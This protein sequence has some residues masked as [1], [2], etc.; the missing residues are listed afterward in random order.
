VAGGSPVTRGRHSPPVAVNGV[1]HSTGRRR[2]REEIVGEVAIAV[3]GCRWA[4][5]ER[6]PDLWARQMACGWGREQRGGGSGRRRVCG[7]RT[8]AR[9]GGGHAP[10]NRAA[11]AAR[12]ARRVGCAGRS[13]G[14]ERMRGCAGAAACFN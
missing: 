8:G 9:R 11:A 4:V 13:A 7:R 1:H 5:E 6:A 14:A 2:L 12:L 3:H 10:G